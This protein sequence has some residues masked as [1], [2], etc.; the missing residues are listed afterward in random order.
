MRL[1]T[2][3]LLLA[4]QS[5]AWLQ[6]ASQSSQ[7]DVV[8]TSGPVAVLSADTDVWLR[9][10]Q[11]IDSKHT[12]TGDAVP[13]EVADDVKA[14]ELLVVAKHT[15]VT[16]TLGSVHRAGRGL[17]RGSLTLEVKAVNDINGNPIPISGSRSAK[18]DPG[19]QIEGYTE[20]ALSMGFLAPVLLFV[21]G[22]EAVLPKGAKINA[23]VAQDVALEAGQLRT[24]MA[25]LDAEEARTHTGK[26]TV[27]FYLYPVLPHT[28][29]T[30][31]LF[32]DGKKVAQLRSARSF[33]MQVEPGA[34]VVQCNGHEMR[35]DAK[36][37]VLYS[38]EVRR[39]GTWQNHWVPKLVESAEG[40]D[41]VYPLDPSDPKDVFVR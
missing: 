30:H 25:A 21:R 5:T 32:L 33:Q 31:M 29:E 13:L 20:T 24:R 10:T 1:R 3:T 41:K 35:L 27:Y 39:E 14:G 12:K 38:I 22:D 2:L 4:L 17:R 36:A 11:P 6:S 7:P 23:V 37:D 18:A 9:T 40:E 19:R 26:A 15:P 28:F 34:H 16:A 8:V